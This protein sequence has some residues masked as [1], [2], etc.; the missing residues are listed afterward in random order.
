MSNTAI[1]ATLAYDGF[2]P[3][4]FKALEKDIAHIFRNI[5][6]PFEQ[7]EAVV[8]KHANFFG[9]QLCL[10]IARDKDDILIWVEEGTGINR[11]DLQTRLAAC[12]HVVRHLLTI[13]RADSVYWHYTGKCYTAEGFEAR[14]ALDTSQGP[15]MP[16]PEPVNENIFGEDFLSVGSTHER[17][18]D[19]FV[20]K[21][22]VRKE[23]AEP[24]DSRAILF[25]EIAEQLEA[26]TRIDEEAEMRDQIR[27]AL[28][29]ET[30]TQ[31]KSGATTVLFGPGRPEDRLDRSETTARLATYAMN[32]TL[33]ITAM[34]VGAALMTYNMLGGENF[35]LTAQ[36]TALTGAFLGTGVM[37][38]FGQILQMI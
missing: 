37:S 27:K 30:P 7:T 4:D 11:A 35:R 12:Y 14:I 2:P 23:A 32:T 20:R 15:I 38:D 9:E 1:R 25:P 6:L 16:E 29:P 31:K 3:I 10:S 28:Y 21:I 19:F 26:A 8:R 5:M 22:T 34:P 36:V 13:E 24:K 17:L 18:D 33:L